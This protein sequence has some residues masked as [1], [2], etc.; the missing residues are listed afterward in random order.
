MLTYKTSKKLVGQRSYR[1]SAWVGRG[2]DCHPEATAGREENQFT[3]SLGSLEAGLPEHPKELWGGAWFFSSGSSGRG[4]PKAPPFPGRVTHTHPTTLGR[5]KLAQRL[6]DAEEA[7]E[8]VNAKCSSL[9]KTKHRLQ[10]EI[11]DLMV[12][13]ERSNAAAAALDKKQRNFDKVG[14]GC[15]PQPGDRAGRQEGVRNIPPGG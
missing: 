12:D 1:R 8:A 10:N 3:R 2:G 14:P 13:V 5:K 7:V 4:G 11:E 9:E 6:Q 15:G